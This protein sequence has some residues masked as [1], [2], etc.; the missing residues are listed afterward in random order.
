MKRFF[1]VLIIAF[2]LAIAQTENKVIYR[3]P[4]PIV[5][6]IDYLPNYQRRIPLKRHFVFNFQFNEAR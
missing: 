1:I 4:V 3:Q 6:K 2:N 5:F